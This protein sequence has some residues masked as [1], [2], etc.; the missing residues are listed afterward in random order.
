MSS[1]I[2]RNVV[3]QNAFG[4]PST[5]SEADAATDALRTLLGTIQWLYF[6]DAR[7]LIVYPDGDTTG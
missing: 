6:D 3:G 5:E 1:I 7:V 2:I 4:I